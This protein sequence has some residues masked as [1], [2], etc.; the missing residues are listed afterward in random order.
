MRAEKKKFAWLGRLDVEDGERFWSG[1]RTF[2]ANL[3]VAGTACVI[4]RPG[5]A[6]RGYG[7]REG[8]AKWLLCRSALISSSNAEPSS[9]SNTADA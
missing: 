2:L 9:P 6:A 1:Y 7:K 3:P 5:Y 4:D 8:D